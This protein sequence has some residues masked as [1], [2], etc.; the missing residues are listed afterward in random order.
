MWTL[1]MKFQCLVC[2][3][4]LGNYTVAVMEAW[5]PFHW[6]YGAAGRLM[7]HNFASDV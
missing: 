6:S 3:G 2:P 7:A 4:E 5:L 1:D